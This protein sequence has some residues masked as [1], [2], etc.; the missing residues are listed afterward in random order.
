MPSEHSTTDLLEAAVLE[1]SGARR[2]GII[3]GGYTQTIVYDTSNV[4]LEIFRLRLDQFVQNVVGMEV[5]D[6]KMTLRISVLGEL[7]RVYHLVR[8]DVLKVK[9]QEDQETN[10]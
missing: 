10:G 3:H 2:V 8:K 4:N 1:V 6:L 5:C 7:M 9:D